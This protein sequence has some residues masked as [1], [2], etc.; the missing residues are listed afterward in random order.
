MCVSC[1]TLKCNQHACT[2]YG[3]VTLQMLEHLPDWVFQLFSLWMHLSFILSPVCLQHPTICCVLA[4]C[5]PLKISDLQQPWLSSLLWPCIFDLAAGGNLSDR[6]CRL[7]SDVFICLIQ[8]TLTFSE[9][10]IFPNTEAGFLPWKVQ[11]RW[12]GGVV[13]IQEKAH[14]VQNLSSAR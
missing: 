11:K 2:A 7:E 8:K 4:A 14:R 1:K 13:F 12:H 6:V 5:R 9:L 10:F 3:Q